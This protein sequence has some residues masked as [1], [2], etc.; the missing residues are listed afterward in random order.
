[1][2][3]FSLG[4]LLLSSAAFAQ[5]SPERVTLTLGEFLKLYEGTKTRP[6]KPE[7][8]PRDYALSNARYDGK[9]VFDDGEPIAATFDARLSVEILK[10]GWVRMPLLDASVAVQKATI[11]GVDAPLVL[12]GGAYV[13]VTDRTGRFDVDIAFATNVTTARG[14]SGFAF[15]LQP[16]G[17][18]SVRLAVDEEDALDFKVANAR[19]KQDKL[20]NGT[21]VVEATLPATGSLAVSWQRSLEQ[22]GPDKKKAEPR[23][24]SEVHTLVGIGDGLLS[25]TATVN[26]TI[27]FAGVDQMQVRIPTGMKVLDVRGTGVRDWKLTDEGLLTALLNYEA[28][29][30]YA[31]KIEMERVLDGTDVQAPVVEPVGVERS[32]GW[33]GVQ[34]RGALEITDGD[35]ENAA[36]VD[37][38]TLPASILGVTDTPVLL[39]Y[40]YLGSNAAIPLSV[41]EHEEV[42]VLVTLLDQAAATTMFTVDGRRLTSV[43]Y[44][45]R[46]NRRQFLRLQMPDGAELWSANVAGRAVQ[47]A[48]SDERLLV[49]LVRS[50]ASGGA[51]ASFGVEVVYVESGVGPANNGKGRFEAKLPIADAPTTYLAWTV[52]APWDAKVKEKDYEGNL[53]ATESLSNPVRTQTALQL[54]YANAPMQQSAGVQASGGGLGEGAAPV[55]VNLPLDG[56]PHF[57]EKLLVLDEEL[58]VGF[59][60]KGLKP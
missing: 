28:K 23:V 58:W 22:T 1:M 36:I 17:A 41:L 30:S 20:V 37:V 59:D 18:T 56:R 2:K 26:Q 16:S 46:N 14:S 10:D 31:L 15:P 52:Y 38:R 3:L 32:K 9:V 39:G 48:Q 35:V 34:A 27:L 47:P 54:D 44:E 25:A 49:P 8:A 55:Q 45:V 7:K 4:L 40:K 51:L 12:E 57:F 29:G 42:D 6:D 19:L 13:L 43:R 24:Y 50:S 33:L 21:R 53:R 60:Y 5:E 11:N